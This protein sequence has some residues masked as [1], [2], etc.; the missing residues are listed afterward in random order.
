MKVGGFMVGTSMAV[1]L[2]LA[3]TKA[4][5]QFVWLLATVQGKNNTKAALR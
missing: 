5:K 1:H 2:K 4:R 3:L